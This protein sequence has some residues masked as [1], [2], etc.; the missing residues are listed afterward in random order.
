MARHEHN[1]TENFQYL[2]RRS[3]GLGVLAKSVV[4][5]V[6]HD[7]QMKERENRQE[8]SIALQDAGL[9]PSRMTFPDG[10]VSLQ[11]LVGTGSF[12]STL[13]STLSHVCPWAVNVVSPLAIGCDA[14]EDVTGAWDPEPA[15]EVSGARER[16][17]NA[18]VTGVVGT[19]I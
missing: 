17:L 18:S 19:A 12:T 16:V 9:M 11:L 13:P 10:A 8:K 15:V 4:C 14:G 7:L 6:H 2:S 3:D 1:H 5:Q